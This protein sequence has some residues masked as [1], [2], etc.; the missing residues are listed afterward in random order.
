VAENESREALNAL[1][2]LPE[3][4]YRSALSLLCD[5]SLKRTS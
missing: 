5:L 1:N 4:D 2:T 3:S